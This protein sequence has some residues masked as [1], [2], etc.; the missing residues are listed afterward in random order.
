MARRL[1]PLNALN[2]PNTIC[3]KETSPI[4]ISY[5]HDGSASHYLEKLLGDCSAFISASG[6]CIISKYS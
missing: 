5:A 3:R 1:D 2:L 4:E 6:A